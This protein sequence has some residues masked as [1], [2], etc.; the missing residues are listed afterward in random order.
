MSKTLFA[1]ILSFL[2]FFALT[3]PV[4]ARVDTF[5]HVC[6][7]PSAIN[8]P[9]YKMKFPDK[10][11]GLNYVKEKIR[12]WQLEGYLE[13]GID[14][15][16]EKEK[17]F[18]LHQGPLYEWV[19]LRM[20]GDLSIPGLMQNEILKGDAVQS[21][22]LHHLAGQVLQF[23]ENNGYP[24]A[25]AYL[26][27]IDLAPGAISA[28]FRVEKGPLV[29]FDT[30]I[31]AGDAKI[32]TGF[33]EQYLGIRSGKPY[34]EEAVRGIRDK[35]NALTFL[36][37]NGDPAVYFSK[38]GARLFLPLQNGGGS[39]FDFLLGILPGNESNNGKLLINGRADLLLSNP[40][41]TGKEIRFLWQNP[42]VLSPMADLEFKMPYLFALPLGMDYKFQ[43]R[44]YDTSYF[45]INHRVGASWF[46]EG[47]NYL[48]ILFE[49][50]SSSLISIDKSSILQT[51][52]LPE[53]LDFRIT[54]SGMEWSASAL[55]NRWNPR[56]GYEILANATGGKKKIRL[57]PKISELSD[58]IPSIETQYEELQ[59]GNGT[60]KVEVDFSYFFPLG[61]RSSLLSRVRSG[62][63]Q[64]R[65][66]F[67]NELFLLGGA[68]SIRGFDEQSLLASG[69][70][71][72]TLEY[73]YIFAPR[74][75]FG[76]FFDMAI[77]D[78]AVT[79]YPS[80]NL[81]MGAGL[82]LALDS[83][84]GIF[85]LS[86]ALGKRTPKTPIQ[87]R[88]AKIHFGYQNYF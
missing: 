46:Y 72:L 49:Q 20:S 43:L 36:D 9:L 24:F 33:L 41:G 51:G 19:S 76:P 75:Y 14:S 29:L 71:I 66:I 6:G 52:S 85:L 2:L 50:S 1:N 79:P 78:N 47:S 32:S 3:H 25:K 82:G 83:K 63:L 37:L 59:Q 4:G 27:S 45:N 77:L 13:A 68:G 56:K 12:D 35:I 70:A 61:Q 30:I 34:S 84:A 17:C 28:V 54:G 38:E 22:Q 87:L 62:T 42:R 67:E 10:R 73:R 64:S 15:I 53:Q 81:P 11:E 8:G 39:R 44:K 26:D 31:I 65:N 69:Y 23:A 18:Y 16:V 5:W 88:N 58:S 86:Y 48:K 40:F 80:T 74:A 7:I 60:L 21:R 55:D 57:N